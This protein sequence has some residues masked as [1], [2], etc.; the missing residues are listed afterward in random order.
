MPALAE[1]AVRLIERAEA[2]GRPLASL[3]VAFVPEGETEPAA[4]GALNARGIAVFEAMTTPELGV[5]AYETEAHDGFVLNEGLIAEIVRARHR[6][7]RQRPA[8]RVNWSS[9]RSTRTTR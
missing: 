7:A 4:R 8:S 9:P 2:A 6:R 5:I 3:R 1:L